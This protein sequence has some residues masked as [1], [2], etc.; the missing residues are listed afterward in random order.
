M[1]EGPTSMRKRTGRLSRLFC[2]ERFPL[3]S[4]IPSAKSHPQNVRADATCPLGKLFPCESFVRRTSKGCGRGRWTNRLISVLTRALLQEMPIVM[5]ASTRMR[6]LQKT[7]AVGTAS[8]FKKTAEPRSVLTTNTI[9][10]MSEGCLCCSVRVNTISTKGCGCL[11][12]HQARGTNSA[13]WMI[14]ASSSSWSSF[15]ER[16]LGLSSR[17][18][19]I[20]YSPWIPKS[21]L[22]TLIKSHVI[23]KD[24]L[25]FCPLIRGSGALSHSRCRLPRG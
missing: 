25:L 16:F 19:T 10:R 12:V 4:I 2:H 3:R 11:R 20:Y 7:M 13:N 1:R 21:G 24:N 9:R 8:T 23:H 5:S 22:L 15:Q 18:N 6:L 14:E 17:E